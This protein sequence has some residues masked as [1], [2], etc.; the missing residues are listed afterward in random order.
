[1]DGS[2]GIQHGEV[3]FERAAPI[4][5]VREPQHS[6]AAWVNPGQGGQLEA[7]RARLTAT[8]SSTIV[9]DRSGPRLDRTRHAALAP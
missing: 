2:T 3:E 6:S 5:A 7:L 9:E 1:M 4:G 8:E